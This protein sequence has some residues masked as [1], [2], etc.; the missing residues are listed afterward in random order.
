MVEAF[1]AELREAS[2]AAQAH[3]LR[4]QRRKKAPRPV[5]VDD[6]TTVEQLQALLP[7]GFRVW[8]DQYDSRWQL[9]LKARRIRSYSFNFYGLAGACLEV[10]TAAWQVHEALGGAPSPYIFSK[11]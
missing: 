2:K 5:L 8:H 9:F 3:D 7:P 6:E 11:A 10:L 1:T 4:G